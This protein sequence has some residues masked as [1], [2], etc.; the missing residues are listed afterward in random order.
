[1][2]PNSYGLLMLLQLNGLSGLD[3]EQLADNDTD[4]LDYLMRAM[5]GAF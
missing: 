1:M 2:P 4:R 5:Q 3:P